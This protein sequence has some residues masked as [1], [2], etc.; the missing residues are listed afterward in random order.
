LLR[1]D[2]NH[3]TKAKGRGLQGF[4]AEGMHIVSMGKPSHTGETEGFY[5]E[6]RRDAY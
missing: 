2:R 1:S 6:G 4:Y 3:R 5:A